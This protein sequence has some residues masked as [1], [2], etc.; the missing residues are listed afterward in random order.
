[1]DP[2]EILGLT[3]PCTKEEIKRKYHQLARKHHPDKL[4]GLNEE[5][6]KIN[7]EKFKKINLAYELL[8]NSEFSNTSK[9]EWKNIWSWSMDTFM[10]NSNVNKLIS[11]IFNS[12]REY[13]KQKK[14]QG[15][16]DDGLNGMFSNFINE[17]NEF[18]KNKGSD[19]H[20]SV[21]V[22]L[23]EIHK[24][25]EKK[26][27][28]VL[29]GHENPI[30]IKVNCGH[31]PKYIYTYITPE[32]KTLF[33][34]ITFIV[35][36]HSTYYLDDIMETND[37]FTEIEI[38]LFEYFKG[39]KKELIDL[40]NNKCIIEIPKC[41]HDN[42]IIKNKGLHYKGN[43][44]VLINVNLPS[45]DKFKNIDSNI[46]DNLLENLEKIYS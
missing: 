33:I 21:E 34:H 30:Y 9:S 11:D 32:D 1:M 17:Y 16:E 35:K 38:N 45:N 15:N 43:M 2:Y 8:N 4:G 40:D 28:L 10:S 18:K 20:I 12:V 46:Y 36:P 14:E 37:I 5:E 7:E 25:K 6:K 26:L 29:N 19:H 3:Y 24:N 23:E 22:T 44:N 42:I 27:R 13:K 39:C 41:N 31:F